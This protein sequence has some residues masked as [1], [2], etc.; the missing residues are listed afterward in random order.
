MSSEAQDSPDDPFDEGLDAAVIA[1]AELVACAK[2][3]G[4]TELEL[5]I[6]DESSVWAVTVKKLGIRKDEKEVL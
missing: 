6:P 2:T 4:L 1:A 5:P 3:V